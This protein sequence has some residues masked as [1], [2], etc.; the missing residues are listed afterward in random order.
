MQR[1]K[2]TIFFLDGPYLLNLESPSSFIKGFFVPSLV[3]IDP[4]VM[5]K[6]ILINFINVFSLFRFYLPLEK[7][8]ALHFNIIESPLSKD[9]F[10][11]FG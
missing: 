7:Y 4:V 5:E 8:V 1:G 6:K 9:A 10:T 2:T 11:M 3:E